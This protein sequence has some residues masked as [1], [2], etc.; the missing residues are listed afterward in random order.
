M[1]CLQWARTAHL[2]ILHHG[3]CQPLSLP[4][5][6]KVHNHWHYINEH[7][8]AERTNVRH[9]WSHIGVYNA[10]DSI[11]DKHD[12]VEE[13]QSKSSFGLLSLQKSEELGSGDWEEK[14]KHAKKLKEVSHSNHKC[15]GVG[16]REHAQC[17]LQ[18]HLTYLSLIN[19]SMTRRKVA[20]WERKV[21][22]NPYR[23]VAQQNQKKSNT[24]VS[25]V[26]LGMFVI[27][28]KSQDHVVDEE[29]CSK[30]SSQRT[31]INIE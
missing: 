7:E 26:V 13:N 14:R 24:H 1:S 15:D 30:Y 9:Y 29:A 2:K 28:K 4:Q 31:K 20:P 3:V 22:Q 19:W 25:E 27:L 11:K 17:H 23:H 5:S 16:G 21:S 8:A 10:K 18:L 12:W 6:V